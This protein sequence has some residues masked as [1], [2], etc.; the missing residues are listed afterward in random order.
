MTKI[1]VFM[2]PAHG[3]RARVP[4]LAVRACRDARDLRHRKEQVDEEVLLDAVEVAC[5]ALLADAIIVAKSLRARSG[6][7]AGRRHSAR[8]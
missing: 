4:I 8:A 6:N 3:H 5:G 7:H 1:D 2:T